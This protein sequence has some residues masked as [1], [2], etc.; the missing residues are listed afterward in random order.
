MAIISNSTFTYNHGV[1][2]S[3]YFRL[4][5][6]LFNAGDKTLVDCFMYSSESDYKSNKQPITS[7]SFY[8]DSVIAS[9]DNNATNVVDKYLLFA[10]QE[11]ITQ[12]QNI[13]PGSTFSIV[14][15]NTTQ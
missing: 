12:L 2:S 8:I 14:G 10:T 13:S 4:S 3:P 9:V 15:I 5:L 11:V 7:I 1:Y 6:Q